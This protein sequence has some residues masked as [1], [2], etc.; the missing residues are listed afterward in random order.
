MI[1]R[2]LTFEE[3]FRS[4]PYLCSMGYPTIGIGKRIGPQGGSLRNYEF[5]CSLTIAKLWLKEEVDK[6]A[7]ELHK[8]EWFGNLDYNR[9]TIIISM[10]YQLGMHGLSKFKRMIA[11]LEKGDFKTASIEA[12][13]SRWAVQTPHRAKRHAEVIRY[14]LLD[15]VYKELW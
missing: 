10:A 2:L 8:K 6:V 1:A 11:A 5:T 12:L 7:T 14:G 3:G 4:E 15:P 13:D 9:Q